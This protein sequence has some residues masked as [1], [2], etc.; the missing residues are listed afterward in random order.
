M[1]NTSKTEYI[2]LAKLKICDLAM[3]LN[4]KPL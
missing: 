4:K 1:Y 2:H 3:T